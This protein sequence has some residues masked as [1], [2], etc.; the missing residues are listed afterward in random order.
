MFFGL[1]A[2]LIRTHARM[3]VT[4][5]VTALSAVGARGARLASAVGD[6]A[7]L[8]FSHAAEALLSAS[9]V[10]VST[11]EVQ[12]EGSDAAA[13]AAAGRGKEATV[14]GGAGGDAGVGVRVSTATCAEG[15]TCVAEAKDGGGVRSLEDAA[16]AAAAAATAAASAAAATAAAAAAAGGRSKRSWAM[17]EEKGKVRARAQDVGKSVPFRPQAFLG[18]GRRLCVSI[19]AVL[20]GTR[21][22]STVQR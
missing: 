9:N 1:S 7:G 12:G 22:I 14:A 3:Q 17:P 21:E 4:V 15:G 19:S 6:A 13:A 5:D 18:Q 10:T 8:A 20:A 11:P 2:G 16:A